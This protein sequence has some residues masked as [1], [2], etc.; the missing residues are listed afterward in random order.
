MIPWEKDDQV[1]RDPR[2]FPSASVV[3][4]STHDTAPID[5]WWPELPEHDRARLAE[6][7]STAAG[8]EDDAGRSLALLGDLYRAK[9]DLALVLVQ[10]LLGSK[11]RINTPA[12][13]GPQNWSWRLPQP[14][15]DL[16]RTSSTAARFEAI[17]GLVR[18]SGR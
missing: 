16:Q 14:I 4:W 13:V 9:S 1:F 5:A 10:E 6:R 15:E 7:A 11:D 18:E 3:S 17:R 12:V 8:P 2:A